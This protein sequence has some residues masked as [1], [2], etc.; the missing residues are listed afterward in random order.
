VSDT[1]PRTAVISGGGTGIGRAVSEAL[2]HDGYHVALLGRRDNVL[3]EAAAAM[4]HLGTVHTHAVDL[5]E[6]DDVERVLLR[7]ADDLGGGVDVV[8][9]NAGRGAARPSESLASHHDA[10]MDAI[11]GNAMTSVLLVE[12]L[13][14]HLS[15]TGRIIFVSSAAATGAGGAAYGAAKAALHGW[16]YDLAVELGPEGVTCNVV[17]PG[18]IDDTELFGGRLSDERRAGFVDR[19]LVKRAG[20]PADVADCV[21]WLA[22]PETGYVTAQ[23]IGVDGGA[24]V[25]PG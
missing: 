8:V 15:D 23:V 9:A 18:F 16:M 5:S 12:G 6:P 25:D 22:A 13:R 2:L 20:R 14:P 3:T 24:L 19:T 4:A 7:V 11:A 1:A 17:S 10:W 21:R